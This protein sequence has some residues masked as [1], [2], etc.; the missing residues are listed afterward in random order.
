MDRGNSDPAQTQAVTDLLSTLGWPGLETINDHLSEYDR[1]DFP[2]ALTQFRDAWTLATAFTS[3][4]TATRR[5]H[6]HGPQPDR[7]V[8]IVCH[9]LAS[10]VVLGGSEHAT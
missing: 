1:P 6:E 5:A 8:R 10:N 9:D 7:N 3:P 2:A 4:P